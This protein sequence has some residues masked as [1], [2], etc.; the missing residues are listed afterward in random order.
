MVRKNC[1]LI[2]IHLLNKCSVDLLLYIGNYWGCLKL[3]KVLPLFRFFWDHLYVPMARKYM[4]IDTL[5]RHLC[6]W[7]SGHLFYELFTITSIFYDIYLNFHVKK[8]DRKQ[9]FTT[10]IWFSTFYT[11]F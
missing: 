6:L 3:K 10:R 5:R 11:P 9:P 7:I 4:P 8:L 2:Q 1:V